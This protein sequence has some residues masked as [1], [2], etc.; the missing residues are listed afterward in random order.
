MQRIVAHFARGD[1]AVH[2]MDNGTE[3]LLHRRRHSEQRRK[4][5]GLDAD[6]ALRHG[7]IVPPAREELVKG[8]LAVVVGPPLLWAQVAPPILAERCVV[9]SEVAH[10]EGAPARVEAEGAGVCAQL[11]GEAR[12]VRIEGADE[13]L[14]SDIHTTGATRGQWALSP[15]TVW[16][17]AWREGRV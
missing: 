11:P 16:E 4:A 6:A 7:V 2:C 15:E 12:K 14:Q 13:H 8:R 9:A 17:G 10:G 5:T 3:V 1:R